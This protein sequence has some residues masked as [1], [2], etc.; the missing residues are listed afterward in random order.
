MNSL[1]ALPTT[2]LLMLTHIRTGRSLEK[3]ATNFVGVEAGM[4]FKATR[5]LDNNAECD[6]F[7]LRIPGRMPQEADT[8]CWCVSCMQALLDN[9]APE[10][11]PAFHPTIEPFVKRHDDSGS[12]VMIQR[13]SSRKFSPLWTCHRS[14]KTSCLLTAIVQQGASIAERSIL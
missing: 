9:Q 7:G 11:I 5:K 6:P 2:W 8:E 13:E 14:P 10:S 4:V 12:G 3:D 1:L